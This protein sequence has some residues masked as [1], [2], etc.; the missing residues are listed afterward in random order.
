MVYQTACEQRRVSCPRFVSWYDAVHCPSKSLLGEMG[1]LTGVSNSLAFRM[2]Q[3]PPRAVL[4]AG[5]T[6]LHGVVLEGGVFAGDDKVTGP[7]QH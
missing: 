7:D 2:P 5:Y 3:L 6:Q 4:D 1:W